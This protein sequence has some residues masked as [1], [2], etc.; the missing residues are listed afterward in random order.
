MIQLP[1]ST[2]PTDTEKGPFPSRAAEHM[3][4]WGS[5][6]LFPHNPVGLKPFPPLGLATV[7]S[8]PQ[9]RADGVR[10]LVWSPAGALHPAWLGEGAQLLVRTVLALW[11]GGSRCGGGVWIP[12]WAKLVLV[13]GADSAEATG[14]LSLYCLGHSEG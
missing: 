12:A 5:K 4:G 8:R 6:V 2:Q 3:A 9:S 13:P 11:G 10:G 7:A 1:T 14:L